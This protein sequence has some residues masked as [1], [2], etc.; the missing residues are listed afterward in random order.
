M[1]VKIVNL[2]LAVI[3]RALAYISL[4]KLRCLARG[5]AALG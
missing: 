5:A 3:S 4:H 2:W 1:K